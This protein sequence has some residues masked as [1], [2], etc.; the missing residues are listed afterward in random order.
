M[1]A[2]EFSSSMCNGFVSVEMIAPR[3]KIRDC[4][5]CFTCRNSAVRDQGDKYFVRNESIRICWKNCMN[6]TEFRSCIWNGLDA[7]ESMSPWC[8]GYHICLTRRRSAVRARANKSFAKKRKKVYGYVERFVWTQQFSSST[9]NGL[10]AVETISPWCKRRDCQ[11]FLTCR[12]SAV[13]ARVVTKVF[14]R[15]ESLWIFWTLSMNATEFSSSMCN[16]LRSVEMIAP[17]CK[18]RDCQICF[19]CRMSAV[20]DQGDKYF[21]RNESIRICWKICM[22]A[23]KFNYCICNGH[24]AVET[25][26]PWCSGYHI[27]LTRRRSAVRACVVTKVLRSES[28]WICWTLCMNATEFSSSMCN[29]FVSV[30]MIAPRCKIRDCQI[31]F[32]CRNSA[33]RD[34]GD[35]YFVRNESIR[36]CWKICM[37]AT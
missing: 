26:S 11:K 23:T 27:C 8:S 37:N 20:R 5:I 13:R 19:T 35:K 33:V 28:L 24:D 29:G 4:Q 9:C 17:R 30:G 14:R 25:M 36:I 7:V 22:N 31:C 12:K 10:V 34:Q 2:T 1:N 32:T 16:G 18:I 6:A 3:C 15:S 21:V